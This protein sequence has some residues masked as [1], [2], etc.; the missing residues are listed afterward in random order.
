MA[1]DDGTRRVVWLLPLPVRTAHTAIT[2]MEAA[3]IVSPAP[4]KRKELP[5]AITRDACSITCW[6]ETSE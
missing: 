5:R 3:S 4:N 1:D 2:G 6:C